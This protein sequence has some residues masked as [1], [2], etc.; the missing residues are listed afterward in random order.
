MY[1][2]RK[3]RSRFSACKEHQ[4]WRL[5]MINP[6]RSGTSSAFSRKIAGGGLIDSVY[7]VGSIYMSVNAANPSTLFGG[8]WQRIQGRFLFAADSAHAAGSTGGEEKHKLTVDEMPSH[9]HTIEGNSFYNYSH[10]QIPFTGMR[11]RPASQNTNKAGGDKPHN[12]MPPY[13]S[14]YMWKRTA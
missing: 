7:P 4:L 8:T 6:F 3:R 11:D 10:Q 5:Q 12:N 1:R 9:S 2:V 14:V 13:I